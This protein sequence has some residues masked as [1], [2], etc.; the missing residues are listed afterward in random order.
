VGTLLYR[1]SF[2][3][4]DWTIWIIQL[5]IVYVGLLLAWFAVLMNVAA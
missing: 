5:G 4:N 2:V 1:L 3:F